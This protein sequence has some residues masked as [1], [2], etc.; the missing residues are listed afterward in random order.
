MT[1][2]EL[3]TL[4]TGTVVEA[5]APVSQAHTAQLAGHSVTREEQHCVPLHQILRAM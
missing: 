5:D 1:Y 2:P 4:H 3:Q